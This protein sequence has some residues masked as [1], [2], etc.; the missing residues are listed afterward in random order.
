[1]LLDSVL[2]DGPR[3]A[4]KLPC[5]LCRHSRRRKT[6]EEWQGIC[7]ECRDLSYAEVNILH[8]NQEHD[9]D[10]VV[11]P[12]NLLRLSRRNCCIAVVCSS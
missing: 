8:W 1:L 7:G 9:P 6:R 12:P 3:F 11:V 10:R 5:L 4:G 2:L